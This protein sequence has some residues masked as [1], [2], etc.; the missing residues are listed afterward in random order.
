VIFA[1][2]RKHR[3]HNVK[4]KIKISRNSD[5]ISVPD[6]TAR[7]NFKPWGFI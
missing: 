2:S 3:A 1:A 6:K 7:T 5:G 4:A